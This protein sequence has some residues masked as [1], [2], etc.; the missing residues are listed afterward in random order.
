MPSESKKGL[1]CVENEDFYEDRTSQACVI[2]IITYFRYL[3]RSITLSIMLHL[4]N[5]PNASNIILYTVRLYYIS[6]IT[7]TFYKF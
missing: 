1:L 3:P 5:F 4:M 2:Y 6:G 7:T